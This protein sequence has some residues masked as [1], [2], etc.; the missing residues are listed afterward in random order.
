MAT[1]IIDA[2]SILSLLE[3]SNDKETEIVLGTYI[4]EVLSLPLGDKFLNVL[5]D[6]DYLSEYPT[7]VLESWIFR[8]VRTALN[9]AVVS[10]VIPNGFTIESLRIINND[11]FLEVS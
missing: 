6:I 1:L 10:G 5:D 3:G 4:S 9:R 2:D 7:D 11:V 8:H